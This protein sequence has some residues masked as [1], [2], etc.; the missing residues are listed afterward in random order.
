MDFPECEQLLGQKKRICR[1]ESNRPLNGPNSTNAYRKKWGFEPIAGG[2]DLQSLSGTVPSPSQRLN[3]T[4][5][6]P[7]G[8]GTE[9]KKITSGKLIPTC[10]ACK[11]HAEAMDAHGVHWCET[12]IDVIV[13]WMKEA[14]AKMHIGWAATA[15]EKVPLF[16]LSPKEMVL[17]AIKNAKTEVDK[18][19]ITREAQRH[20]RKHLK[21]TAR[22]AAK[23]RWTEAGYTQVQLPIVEQRRKG[24]AGCS[25]NRK[26][27]CLISENKIEDI[28]HLPWEECPTGV[29]L[30]AP[31]SSTR[32]ARPP[33]RHLIYHLWPKRN[34]I[35]KWNVEEL[36]QRIE[37]FNG[38]RSI[39]VALDSTTATIEEV[40]TVFKKHRIDNWIVVPN[41]MPLGEGAT[42]PQLLDTLP[43]DSGIT[44]YA[45]AKGVKYS[46]PTHPTRRWASM[47]YETCLDDPD[48]VQRALENFPIVGSFKRYTGLRTAHWHYSGTYYWFRNNDVFEKPNWRTIHHF[49]GCVE[50]WP[51]FMFDDADAGCLFGEASDNLY[52]PNYL[53]EMQERL[54][55]WRTARNAKL[56]TIS[57]VVPTMGRQSLQG[58]LRAILTQLRPGDE[59][60][61][62]AD[63]PEA[64]KRCLPHVDG[65]KYFEHS[66]PLSEYGHAQRNEG[67]RQATGDL[68]WY[69]D[70]D[71]IVMPDSLQK[72]RSEMYRSQVPTLFKIKHY[73]DVLWK[74]FNT[75]VGNISGQMLVHPN[76]ESIPYWRIPSADAPRGDNEWI[77]DIEKVMPIDWNEQII[78]EL[79]QHSV[80]K[81]QPPSH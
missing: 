40:K 21:I 44:F 46:V 25:M 8:V 23:T 59:I 53:N 19:R 70:D 48:S 81:L 58:V 36:I 10:G 31:Q 35:W 57:V 1:G 12:H 22:E 37:Q 3:R 72:I 67:R 28:V 32:F 34:G 80:G 63:G 51:A 65:V 39:G 14:A 76:N 75:D 54:D 62:V 60:I 47:Q 56:P 9:L 50:H 7:I 33:K 6:P 52:D 42:Y 15:T 27:V 68:I 5:H 13:G 16:G 66:D 18:L 45:H 61:A 43:R 17:Q 38:V 64:A 71:D 29:W 49:Y 78:Y 4:Y 24:C 2:G 77:K 79:R 11:N 41:Q 20:N 30:Q 69:V 55:V 74:G 73:D 26:G